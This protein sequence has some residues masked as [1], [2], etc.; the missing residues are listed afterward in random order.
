MTQ[1]TTQRSAGRTA[2][3]PALPWGEGFILLTM[4]VL[5]AGSA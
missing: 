3:F 4:L 2:T 1:Q 5:L